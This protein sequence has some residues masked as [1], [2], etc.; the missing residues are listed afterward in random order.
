ML[1][2]LL[3]DLSHFHYN[4]NS[5]ERQFENIYILKNDGI[6]LGSLDEAKITLSLHSKY[7]NDLTNKNFCSI[8]KTANT[9]GDLGIETELSKAKLAWEFKSMNNYKDCLF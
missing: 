3:Q 8:L 9:N 6:V 7:L 2:L 1:A 5:G 4:F